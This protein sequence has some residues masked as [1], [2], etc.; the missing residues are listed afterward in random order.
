MVS[1]LSKLA[2]LDRDAAQVLRRVPGVTIRGDQFVQVRGLSSD[3]PVMLHNMHPALKQN[4]R[5]FS[6]PDPAQQPTDRMLVF[7]SPAADVPGDFGG[8]VKFFTKSIPAR[9]MDL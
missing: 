2:N 3:N 6:F 8:V 9:R 4:I 7:K 1:P 5:S